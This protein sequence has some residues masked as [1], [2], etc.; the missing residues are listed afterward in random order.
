MGR[1]HEKAGRKAWLIHH[2]QGS[3][4]CALG[5]DLI[6]LATGEGRGCRRGLL[7]SW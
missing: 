4:P 2:L 5:S 6:W 7:V 3:P 1:G